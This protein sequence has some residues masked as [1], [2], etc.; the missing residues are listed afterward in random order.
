MI[1][2]GRRVRFVRRRVVLLLH[3]R[4]VLSLVHACVERRVPNR[5]NSRLNQRPLG[6]LISERNIFAQR[7]RSTERVVNVRYFARDREA[8]LALIRCALRLVLLVRRIH[9]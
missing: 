7:Q 8:R 2:G 3:D 4:V 5:F 6:R 9:R 1:A